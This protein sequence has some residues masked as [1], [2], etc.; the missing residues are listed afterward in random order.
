MGTGVGG[1]ESFAIDHDYYITLMST[2]LTANMTR[3]QA[4]DNFRRLINKTPQ[5]A[6]P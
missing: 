5:A 3:G 6:T 2:R 4:V 1:Y